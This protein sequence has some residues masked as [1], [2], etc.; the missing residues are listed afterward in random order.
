VYQASLLPALIVKTW[1]QSTGSKDFSFVGQG[2]DGQIYAL[3]CVGDRDTLPLTEWVC[4]HL[5]IAA[6]IAVPGF[7][8]MLTPENEAVFA[9]RWEGGKL[10]FTPT[11]LTRL[12][13]STR[14]SAIYVLDL[15]LQNIDRHQNNFH[16]FE[17]GGRVVVL[18]YDFSRCFLWHQL[19]LPPVPIHPDCETRFTRRA[20]EKH[21]PFNLAVGLETL[22]LIEKVPAEKVA[23]WIDAAPALWVKDGLRDQILT[24]WRA[25]ASARV[26]AIGEGL[27]NGTFL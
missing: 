23:E 1:P 13:D 21:A 15:F 3:K 5:A 10:D 16:F 14:L 4:Y 12:A 8:I 17:A 6:R 19:P 24:W 11:V 9:S 2:E 22:D 26:V 7:R 20:M 18:A 25:N 27:K